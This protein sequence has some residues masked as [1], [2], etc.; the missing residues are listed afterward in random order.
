M[1]SRRCG[2]NGHPLMQCR[3]I[4]FM[5][6]LPEFLRYVEKYLESVPDAEDRAK[7]VFLT[8]ETAAIFAKTNPAA[9]PGESTSIAL[10]YEAATRHTGRANNLK[11]GVTVTMDPDD[12]GVAVLAEEA[13]R[14][15][16]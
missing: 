10:T 8:I 12:P 14:P 3:Y 16:P 15:N 6:S 5:T 13:G 1:P 4:S 9:A 11:R 2:S 7:A